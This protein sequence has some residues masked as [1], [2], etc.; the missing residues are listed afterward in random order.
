MKKKRFLPNS[1]G[2][3]I[4]N[5][6][7]FD[8][9]SVF[10]YYCKLFLAVFLIPFF[11]FNSIM[12]TYYYKTLSLRSEMSARDDFSNV[13]SAVSGIISE[14]ESVY[15]TL[16]RESTLTSFMSAKSLDE[17]GYHYKNLLELDEMADN[18]SDISG[19]INSIIIYSK[20]CDYVL[21]RGKNGFTESFADEIW[22][23]KRGKADCQYYFMPKD[24][25]FYM[26]YNVFGNNEPIGLVIFDIDPS[27]LPTNENIG[28]FLS[29]S[30]GNLF[31]KCGDNLFAKDAR[32]V[33]AEGNDKINISHDNGKFFIASNINQIRINMTIADTDGY[34]TDLVVYS[35]LSLVLTIVIS[36][37]LAIAVS[38]KSYAMLDKILL[39]IGEGEYAPDAQSQNEINFI[40]S[41]LMRMRT[42]NTSLQ[43]ELSTSAYALKQMQIEALQMQFN[44][45]F[46]FN[47]LNSLS[48]KLTKEHGINS[49][50]SS[51]IVL[52]SDILCESLNTSHYMVRISDEI[53]YA[54]KYLDF[55]KLAD[56]YLFDT[57][58]ETDENIMDCYTV[59]LSMQ[60]IIENAVKHGI[61]SLRNE[62]KGNITI[63]IFEENDNIV[64]RI[65]NTSAGIDKETV[66]NANISLKSGEMPSSKNIGLKN[67]NKRIQLVF[68]DMYG[69]QVYADDTVFTVEMKIPKIENL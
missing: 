38:V 4:S 45:H 61:K 42:R 11:I 46:L 67:V 69:C 6:R 48:M 41:S 28:L 10:Y 51:L 52:L 55:Q 64:F 65:S 68:G 18:Y 53:T 27:S 34:T 62:T 23:K 43:E 16:L 54:R 35:V 22:L 19:A 3:S 12:I 63:K 8:K 17:M 66:E 59:K 31:Y 49:P 50:Y 44:P 47:A 32:L 60:P 14:T 20:N 29:D 13:S 58:W 37:I 33:S 21:S 25:G 36:L 40:I 9:N 7:I 56:T 26:C 57:V 1:F 39:E 24:S 30:E 15:L 2:K 5:I